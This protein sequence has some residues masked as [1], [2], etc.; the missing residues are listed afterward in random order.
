[1]I[2]SFP[3]INF[4]LIFDSAQK[5][6]DYHKLENLSSSH[7]L[8]AFEEEFTDFKNMLMKSPKVKSMFGKNLSGKNLA[9]LAVELS[10]AK[11]PVLKYVY[12]DIFYYE[13]KESITDSEY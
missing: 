9:D 2:A 3:F 5:I 13:I 8:P 4:R 10:T 1:L 6:E 12:V 11:I 7:V